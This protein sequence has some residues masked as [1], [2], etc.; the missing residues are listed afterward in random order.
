MNSLLG[1]LQ[2]GRLVELPAD[3]DKVR[4]LTV[5]AKLIEAVPSVPPGTDVAAGVVLRESAG[6]TALG[7]GWACPHA[8]LEREGDLQCAVG[9]SPSG[10]EYGAPD[11]RPVH[12]LVMYLVPLDQ[13][14]AYL[15]EISGIAKALQAQPDDALWARVRDLT[16]VRDALSDVIR[17]SSGSSAPEA[18]ARMIQLAARQESTAGQPAGTA[19]KG[20]A[21][22][23]VTIVGGPSVKPVILTQHRELM[24]QLETVPDLVATLARQGAVD[25]GAWRVVS[26]GAAACRS[27]RAVFDCLAVKRGPERPAAQRPPP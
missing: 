3:R 5:L 9:W 13:K 8:R 25:A 27:E 24:E 14:N 4:A 16:Q 23:P 18:R 7:K 22:Q 17:A 15:R 6:S 21:V 10:V 26:P 20:L 1:A 2:E 19:L 11:G 12:I